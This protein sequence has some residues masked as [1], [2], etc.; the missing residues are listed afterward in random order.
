[1]SVMVWSSRTFLAM[2][3]SSLL[4]ISADAIG[5]RPLV[6]MSL[7]ISCLLHSVAQISTSRYGDGTRSDDGG[8]SL[9]SERYT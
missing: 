8:S 9:A 1:M 7:A 6:H 5:S 4:A 2:D 3:L